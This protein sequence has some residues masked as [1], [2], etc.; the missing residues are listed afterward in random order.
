MTALMAVILHGST[1]P[2]P[3]P[4]ERSERE[5]GPITTGGSV[6]RAGATS[7]VTTNSDGYGSPKFSNEVQH[8]IR[9]LRW[10][11]NMTSF[12]WKTGVRLPGF[13]QRA[14]RSGKSRQLWIARH[15]LYPGS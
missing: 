2:S 13:M 10:T 6:G 1:G 3:R 14:A 12:R 4:S 15:R 11:D 8:Q 7:D 9:V 5:P